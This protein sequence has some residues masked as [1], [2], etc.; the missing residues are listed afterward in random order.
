VT[1]E[2]SGGGLES[3]RVLVT[4]PAE[5]AGPL[6]EA[7]RA[8]G[9]TPLLYPTIEVTEPPDWTPF[10]AAFGAAACGDWVVFTSPS[11]V[12]LAAARLRKTGRA[13]ALSALKIAAVGPGTAAALLAEGWR[14]ELVPDSG[15]RNQEGLAAALS[16]LG[17]GTRVLFPRALEGRDELVR[18]LTERQV[19]VQVV[20]VS[21]T[22]ARLLPPL[23]DFD[24]AI[25]ASPSAL[26]ALVERWG[27]VALAGRV[28]IAIGPVTAQ[29]MRAAAIEPSAVA[30]DPTTD[31]VV[32]ALRSCWRP[33]PG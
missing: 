28:T 30:G 12:R 19:A 25:F 9:A 7:L 13:Q 22:A 1:R 5:Q 20:P 14:A 27:V 4:R 10:D 31:G 15:Q 24:A 6:A 2:A 18:Q 33:A 11:A 29:A 21:R 8:A 3:C 17:P 23:P 32:A 16:G 26:R